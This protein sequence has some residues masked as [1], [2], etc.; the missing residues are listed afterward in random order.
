MS[1]FDKALWLIGNY[2]TYVA[3]GAITVG[4]AVKL[5]TAGRQVKP[6]DATADV[7]V[8]FA[9]RSCEMCRQQ[10]ME[11]KQYDDSHSD[12]FPL[13]FIYSPGKKLQAVA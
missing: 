5:G 13:Y 1:G 7:C 10:F 9:Y 2:H 11:R 3:E 12:S 6:T 8:G 4:L